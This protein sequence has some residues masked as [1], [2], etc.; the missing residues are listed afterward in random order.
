MP[1]KTETIINS[2]NTFFEDNETYTRKELLEFAKKTYD[3]NCKKS[4][5]VVD[6]NVEKKPLNAYQ[7]FMKEQRIIL[8]K[9]ENERTDGEKISSQDLMREIAGM[10]KQQKARLETKV[11]FLD[12]IKEDTKEETKE[13][14]KE[15]KKEA[16]K[17]ET[18]ELKISDDE[19]HKEAKVIPKKKNVG[20]K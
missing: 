11:G 13:L 18:N 7:L 5:K 12:E 2:F 16:K 3:E 6:E 20:K 17:E 4:K 8:N 15:L 14:K 9:R 1:S 19:E 10:W